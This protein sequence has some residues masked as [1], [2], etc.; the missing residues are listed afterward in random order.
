MPHL[1]RGDLKPGLCHSAVM[2]KEGCEAG[3]RCSVYST[4]HTIGPTA[5]LG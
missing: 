5:I 3:I 1:P 4:L 2:G